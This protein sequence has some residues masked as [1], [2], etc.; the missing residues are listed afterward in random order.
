MLFLFIVSLFLDLVKVVYSGLVL[1]N[2]YKRFSRGH[3]KW[4]IT[5]NVVNLLAYWTFAIFQIKRY[6]QLDGVILA[7]AMSV[8]FP[9]FSLYSYLIRKERRREGLLIIEGRSEGD[10]T[11]APRTKRR[12]RH[13]SEND[14]ETPIN[15]KK[16]ESYVRAGSVVSDDK[17]G[18]SGYTK[19]KIY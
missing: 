18:V 8:T 19:S 14:A 2:C 5:S 4:V 9:L 12:R 10:E 11:G 3:F 13:F 1:M 16:N 7:G 17:S 15:K 6:S